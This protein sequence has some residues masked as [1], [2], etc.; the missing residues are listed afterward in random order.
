MFA[1]EPAQ[2][3]AAQPGGKGAGRTALHAV[4]I[5]AVMKKLGSPGA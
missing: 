4:R 3:C 2:P 5:L 1:A